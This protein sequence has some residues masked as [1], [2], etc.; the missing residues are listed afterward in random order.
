[1]K[2]A[3]KRLLPS[4]QILICSTRRAARTAGKTIAFVDASNRRI[5]RMERRAYMD[6]RQ[7]VAT[8]AIRRTT[9]RPQYRLD[10]LMAQIP[11]DTRFEEF[12]VGPPVGREVL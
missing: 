2:Q 11:A 10:Q 1:M 3:K 8:A 6:F 4:I 9:S 7:K 12:D 5:A